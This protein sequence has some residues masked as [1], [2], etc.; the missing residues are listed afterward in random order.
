MINVFFRKFYKNFRMKR[1]MENESE[2]SSEKN[3]LEKILEHKAI[4]FI[5]FGVIIRIGILLYYYYTHKIDPGRSWGDL[6]SYFD[7]NLTSTPLAVFFLEVFR[8]FSFGSI[9][10]FAFW[11]FFCDLL[12][13]LMFYFVLKNFKVKNINYALGLFAVNPFFF[14]NNAFSLENCGYHITDA[15]FFFFFFLALIYYPKEE[16]YAKYLFYIFLGLSMCTKYYTLPAVGFLFLK[17]L[18]ERNWKEMKIFVISIAPSLIIL[19]IIPLFITDWFLDSLTDWSTFGS[20]VPLF[21]R[22][23]PACILALLFIIF[24][25]KDADQFEISVFS[26]VITASFMVFSFIYARWFQAIL[27]YGILKEREFFSFKLNLGFIKREI[28][29]DN[30]VLTFYLSFIAV[31]IA[32][33]FI[34]FLY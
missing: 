24:R 30:H 26:T 3:L 29:V 12:T 9:G 20:D 34:I 15:F 27:F 25:L 6:G 16:G 22:I 32:Y 1:Y 8:F 4:L 7:D 17:Y 19:L 31:F 21:I 33:L 10:I 28:K 2:L 13:V 14:L 5:I 11:G 18:I 23:I